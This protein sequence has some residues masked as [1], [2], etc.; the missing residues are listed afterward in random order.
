MKKGI[1]IILLTISYCLPVFGFEYYSNRAPYFKDWE[2]EIFKEKGFYDGDPS[3]NIILEKTE[4][5]IVIKNSSIKSIS[6]EIVYM[7]STSSERKVSF[8][9]EVFLLEAEVHCNSLGIDKKHIQFYEPLSEDTLYV[10][11]G[12]TQILRLEPDIRMDSNLSQIRRSEKLQ[13]LHASIRCYRKYDNEAEENKAYKNFEKFFGLSCEEAKPI[14]E[15]KYP[16]MNPY[17]VNEDF[18]RYKKFSHKKFIY[19]LKK[20]VFYGDSSEIIPASSGT[21][22]FISSDGHIITNNHVIDSCSKIEINYDGKSELVN[23]IAIDQINDLA[24][25]KSN[26]KTKNFFT[27][28]EKDIGLLEEVY[29]AGFPFGKEISSSV[30][31]TKGVVSSLSGVGDNYSNMQIDAALQPGNSGG[32]II[33]KKGNVVGVAVAK[34]DFTKVIEIFGAIPEDTNFGIKSSILKT[35]LTSNNISLVNASKKQINI[36][37]IKELINNSTLYLGCWM[38]QAKIKE[39][40]SRKV[41]FTNIK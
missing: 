14:L 9:P 8:V 6:M 23:T 21:G 33:D 5:Y 34:L 17:K 10:L 19:D 40:Q 28:S 39:L 41:M 35:F 37:A 1:V 12:N 26:S 32:P 25:L 24:L 15:K 22:F 31:V 3:Q 13:L 38:T 36:N 29:V 2:I 18:E 20:R 4:D 16:N 7:E 30:K 11:C 27:I